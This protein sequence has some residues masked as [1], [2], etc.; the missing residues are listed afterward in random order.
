MMDVKF[1]VDFMRTSFMDEGQTLT[2]PMNSECKWR[3]SGIEGFT[4][5]AGLDTDD[6][7]GFVSDP[8]VAGDSFCCTELLH[9]VDLGEII[10]KKFIIVCSR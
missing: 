1:S 3:L 2:C 8:R 5:G 7:I 9:P 6:M 10:K 4:S